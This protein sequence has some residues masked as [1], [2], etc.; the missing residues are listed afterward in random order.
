MQAAAELLGG[1][2]RLVAV[3]DGARGDEHQQLGAALVVEG[4]EQVAEHGNL[5]QAVGDA[6]L[7]LVLVV[8]DQA[9]QDDGVAALY[10]HGALDLALPMRGE[11][12][13]A[14]GGG[15]EALLLLHFHDHQ[16]TGVDAGLRLP[17]RAW[18]CGT[19]CC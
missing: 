5:V 18:W 15:G 8:L 10:R 11:A 2:Q 4:A 1:L 3:V 9:A 16:A 17:S 14:G 7:G 12:V 19:R 6:G 13:G